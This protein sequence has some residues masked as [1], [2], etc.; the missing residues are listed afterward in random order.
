MWDREETR[1]CSVCI[2]RRWRKREERKKEGSERERERRHAGR[3]RMVCP[4]WRQKSFLVLR[5]LPSAWPD[6]LSSVL[7]IYLS[8]SSSG[9]SRRSNSL[10][11]SLS[12][13]LRR[14]TRWR[15][16]KINN[17]S[18]SRR[19]VPDSTSRLSENPRDSPSDSY[20]QT[21]LSPLSSR[22]VTN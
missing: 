13:S 4:E 21:P 2:E 18:L 19:R 20:A 14:G 11:P 10:S 8:S 6:P 22:P 5:S 16:R 12:L 1:V 7:R 15:N 9:R 3:K 17:P